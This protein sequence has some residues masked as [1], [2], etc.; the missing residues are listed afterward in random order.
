MSSVGTRGVGAVAGTRGF[1]V[2][3]ARVGEM[4]A[5]KEG[6]LGTC[7]A[8]GMWFSSGAVSNSIGQCGI[9]LIASRFGFEV[10]KWNQLRDGTV[11]TC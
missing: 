8:V 5:S 1:V 7:C 3:L 6:S 11:M 4:F 2:F 10:Q 9:R